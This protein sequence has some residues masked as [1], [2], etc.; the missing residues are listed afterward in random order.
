VNTIS[1]DNCDNYFAASQSCA[2]LLAVSGIVR[3]L[4]NETKNIGGTAYGK[5]V[6]ANMSFNPYGLCNFTNRCQLQEVATHEFGHALGLGHSSDTN[7]TMAPY[8]HF[9]NRCAS[10]TPDDVRGVTSIYPGGS[11]GAGLSIMTSDL[12]AANADRDY[13]VNLE[14]IG[15]TGGYHWDLVSGHLPLGLQLG[16]SGLLFGKPGV[17]GTFTLVAQVRDSSGNTSQ[18]SYTLAVRPP[19]SRH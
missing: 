4:P 2:G 12:P 18:S 16:M 14:A 13:S 1:F 15:G 19:V 5:A 9:D 6:E 3:Y 8:V 7:A 17:P 11:A 10:L